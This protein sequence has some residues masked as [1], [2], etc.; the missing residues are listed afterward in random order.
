MI[1]RVSSAG[2]IVWAALLAGCGKAPP[3]PIIAAEGVVR[4]NGKPLNKV[5]VRF[6]PLIDYGAEYVATGITDETGRFKLTCHG[7]PGAC[8]GEN[9]VLVVESAI[10]ARLQGEDAQA[11][12][13][14][15]FRSLG[16]RP[17]PAKYGSLTDTPLTADVNTNQREYNFDLTP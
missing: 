15:Y 6:I 17:I 2:A 4:L 11:E 8:A 7:Q 9:R 10:P 14:K 12:L 1:R 16:G 5:E 3:P 13:A